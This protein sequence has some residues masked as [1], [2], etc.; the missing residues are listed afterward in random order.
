MGLIRHSLQEAIEAGGLA[1]VKTK[2]QQLCTQRFNCQPSYAVINT[3]GPPHAPIF[4]VVLR[5]GEQTIASAIGKSK[6]E[7]EQHAAQ[8]ALQRLNNVKS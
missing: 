6:K 5:I 2:L 4:T 1:D 3:E 8:E 7:A